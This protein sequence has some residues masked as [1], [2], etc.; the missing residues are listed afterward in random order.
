MAKS[1]AI[2]I[3]KVE[4]HAIGQYLPEVVPL[5][6]LAAVPQ[7]PHYMMPPSNHKTAN[8]KIAALERRAD[9]VDGS[10][11]QIRENSLPIPWR[12]FAAIG[13][14]TCA[15][16]G[17]VV[18]FYVDRHVPVEIGE[19][20]GPLV[21]RIEALEKQSTSK[22]IEDLRIN[23]SKQIEDLRIN[24]TNTIESVRQSL[25]EKIDSNDVRINQRLNNYID[26]IARN[27]R[28]LHHSFAHAVSVKRNRMGKS[29]P[30]AQELLVRA[31]NQGTVLS[32]KDI[33]K[34]A[35]LALPLLDKK[36]KDPKV[37]NEAWNTVSELASYKSF[38]DGRFSPPPAFT[39]DC[40]SGVVDMGGIALENKVF[41]DC[42]LHYQGGD[43][44]LKNVR[45]IN[46]TFDLVDERDSRIFLARFLLSDKAAFSLDTAPPR[47]PSMIK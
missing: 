43:I 36:Y 5:P 7:E 13:L 46:A 19:S 20:V 3:D 44:I 10:L 14:G 40:T 11:R 35:R 2:I 18:T 42:N 31:R 9:S 17:G 4:D 32:Y 30:V 12:Y 38:V 27:P 34:L 1:A 45:F 39:N 15:L 26:G 29:L 23:S 41:V 16:V 6:S 37:Y 33:R 28:K 25:G 22:Q 21:S 47:S 24:L 8:D